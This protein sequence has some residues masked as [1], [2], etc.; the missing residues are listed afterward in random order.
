MSKCLVV[1]GSKYGSTAEV[2]RAIAEGLD[3]EVVDVAGKPDVS[4]YDV[5]VIG[6]PI[7]AG[8]YLNSVT[9]FIRDNKNSL[10]DR[11]I[12]AFITAAADMELDPGLT[13]EEDEELYTQQE[14]ADG[15]AE[16]AGGERLAAR[17]F[18]GRLVPD[19]LDERDYKTLSWFYRFLMHGELQGFDLLDLPEAQRWG[20]QLRS[21]LD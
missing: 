10:Q 14:Y 11:K 5:I 2:A 7:Y 1:F 17:G 21:M 4:E 3:A 9:R 6:S 20:E 8:D 19:Q 16:M 12:G 15:L 18:G 13:G